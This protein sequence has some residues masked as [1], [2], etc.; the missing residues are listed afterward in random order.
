MNYKQRQPQLRITNRCA[1]SARWRRTITALIGL[2]A[3]GGLGSCQHLTAPHHTAA[4]TDSNINNNAQ[5]ES[6]H[7]KSSHLKDFYLKGFYLKGKVSLRQEAPNRQ[8][9]TRLYTATLQWKQA[10]KRYGIDLSAPLNQ[11]HIKIVGD[12]HLATV[13]DSN[14][15][16]HQSDNPE[17]LLQDVTG[18][19]FPLKEL[20]QWITGQPDL[21]GINNDQISWQPNRDGVSQLASFKK[22]GWQVRYQSWS[23]WREHWLPKK[24]ELRDSTRVIKIFIYAWD[25]LTFAPTQ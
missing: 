12:E 5:S 7:L 13:W 22:A 15:N 11:G 4:D 16:A 17:Q 2:V 24:I 9:N 23:K 6:S 8:Q 1:R 18:V 3:L 20:Q 19:A 14:A 10:D 25:Q 21:S